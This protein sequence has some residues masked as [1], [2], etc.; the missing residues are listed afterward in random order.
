MVNVFQS[1]VT[2]S[3]KRSLLDL[4]DLHTCHSDQ[5]TSLIFSFLSFSQSISC[6]VN[7]PIW[8]SQ[9]LGKHNIKCIEDI[10]HEIYTVG[11]KFKVVNKV[12]NFFSSIFCTLS[13][14]RS[15]C[16]FIFWYS[17]VVLQFLWPFKLSSPKGGF[18]K[19]LVHFVEGGDA[20]NREHHINELIRQMNWFSSSIK[21]FTCFFDLNSIDL[22]LSVVLPFW[23]VSINDKIHFILFVCC[24]RHI[25]TSFSIWKV[26]LSILFLH[27][28]RF[29]VFWTQKI[30]SFL[31][32]NLCSSTMQNL[33]FLC[34]DTFSQSK[35][36]S[37]VC[38]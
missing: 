1:P 19:K 2:K 10:I 26:S 32:K 35:C 25:Q 36:E 13:N 20:G 5:S 28:V 37:N 8:F 31:Q 12:S 6:F 33:T 16:W 38:G 18:K 29:I 34:W 4:T 3:L 15:D 30:I 22:I 11:P 21:I 23:K 17:L 9:R 27:F 7:S 24:E 14:S